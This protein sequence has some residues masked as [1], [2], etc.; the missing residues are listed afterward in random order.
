M[1]GAARVAGAAESAPSRGGA[2]LPAR[3]TCPGA[4]PD[5]SR[6][7]RLLLAGEGSAERPGLPPAVPMEQVR[8]INVQRLLEAAEFLERRDRG[9][10]WTPPPLPLPEPAHSSSARGVRCG[11]CE[12]CVCK[13]RCL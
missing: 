10:G 1:A 13:E 4:A 2:G 8:M 3:R 5:C 12:G 6:L 11:W 7:R 9:N